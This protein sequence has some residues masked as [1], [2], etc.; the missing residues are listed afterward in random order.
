M[1]GFK[2]GEK[3]CRKLYV[4]Y[5]VAGMPVLSVDR[6]VLRMQNLISVASI[7]AIKKAEIVFRISYTSYRDL[8]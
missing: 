1:P 2:G 8:S 4:I 3:P 5:P 7:A 6:V